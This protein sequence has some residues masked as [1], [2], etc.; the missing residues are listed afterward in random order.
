MYIVTDMTKQN[1]EYYTADESR[2][3]LHAKHPLLQNRRAIELIREDK[4]EDVLA[5]IDRLANSAHI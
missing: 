4:M 3:W 5:V 2:L 1:K